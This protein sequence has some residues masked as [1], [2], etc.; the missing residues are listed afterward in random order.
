MRVLFLLDEIFAT[1]ERPLI[2]RLEVGLADD[3]VR[4]V[5]AVPDT[6]GDTAPGG[7][8]V[9]TASF[10]L[11]GLALSRK[12][13]ARR[14]VDLVRG[15]EKRPIDIVHVMGG[16]AWLFAADVARL[17]GAPL[18]LELWRT[19]LAP[20]AKALRALL[21][22]TTRLA[23]LCPDDGTV[24][25]LQAAGLGDIAS[26]TPWGV[27]IPEDERSV[28]PPDLAASIV[29]V[30]SGRD[31]RA[32]ITA[33]E[34]I[35]KAI[36]SSNDARVCIDAD[37]A[38]RAR[39]WPVLERLG[40]TERCSLIEGIESRRDLALMS[41]V[42]LV[43]EALGEHRTIILDAMGAGM[44]VVAAPDRCVSWLIDGTTAKLVRNP[45][46]SGAHA[47]S[48]TADDWDAAISQILLNPEAGRALGHSAREY[49]REHRRASAHVAAVMAAYA[50]LT[51]AETPNEAGPAQGQR[52][53]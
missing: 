44:A 1:R 2:E 53:P 51:G 16:A 12:S 50:S 36:P 49:V 11:K 52:V 28:L 38:R 21:T 19:G 14:L 7:F 17:V 41:D 23:A 18:A 39:L 43:P 40:L 6:L 46:G 47:P 20:R 4:I 32:L 22:P 5:R 29:V 34:G 24:Q 26:L 31:A 10:A 8:F 9:E 35:A 15:N 3:G 30:G 13:R 45:H 48:P 25:E 42:L 37:A 27:H 33:M